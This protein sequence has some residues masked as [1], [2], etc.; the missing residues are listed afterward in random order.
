MLSKRA[1]AINPSPTILIDSKAKEMKN[2]GIDVIGFGAGEPDF[3]TPLHIKEAGI[4]AIKSGETRYTPTAGTLELK[5]AICHKLASDNNLEYKPNQIVVS[6]GAKHSLSNSLN[7]LI[8]D[9]DE[10]LI[11]APY[12]VSY[13]ELVKLHGGVPVI[14]ETDESSC[15]KISINELE[16]AVSN[17]SK[18]LI[19][20]SPSNPTGQIYTRKELVD[21]ADF[22]SNN[23]LYIIADEI[24]E[25]LI[26]GQST[27]TSIAEIGDPVKNNTIIVNGVSKSYA[28]TGWRIGYT[29]S[30]V[31]IA[32]AMANIQ[33]HTTSNPNTIA[34]KAALAALSGSQKCIDEMLNAFDERRKYMYQ[35]IIN[36]KELKALEPLGAFYVFVNIEAVVGKS[37]K[38]T[39]IA[40]S[41]D[42]SKL[43]LEH[44]RVALV[45]GTGFGADKCIRLSFA[46]SMEKITEGLN[47][48]NEFV[49]NI[50]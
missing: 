43:L 19:L 32:S 46:T 7:A 44:Y 14:I 33:S 40:N 12:W 6:N 17:K 13:P 26:Y 18:V 21:I 47:R 9:G 48:L 8:D 36:M 27:H 3:E 1:K 41:D 34:Q 31:E 25:K 38:K 45:P 42:F 5:E 20:N 35:R 24:Y 10:A 2:Q 11:P 28:M 29:A 4:N 23:N 22:C 16:K 50:S 49:N 30:S 37:Y 39:V 15:F